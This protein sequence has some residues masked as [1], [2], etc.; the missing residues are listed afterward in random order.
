[1]CGV[2]MQARVYIIMRYLRIC[3]PC[4][5]CANVHVLFS[6]SLLSSPP[7]LAKLQ[8]ADLITSKECS[9]ANAVGG[10][11]L[12]RVSDVIRIQ[13]KKSHDV[14]T[15]TAEVLRSRGFERESEFLSGKQV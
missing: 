5:V 15:K 14:I 13:S 11:G 2:C 1:M 3:T 10:K 9:E 8:Q 4:L 7:V 6:L 12:S